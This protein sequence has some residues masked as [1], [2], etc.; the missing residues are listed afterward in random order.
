M[1]HNRFSIVSVDK[2]ARTVRVRGAAD[3][4]TD[5]SCGEA[6]IVTGEGPTHDLEQL[7]AGDIVTLEQKD[8]RAEQIRVVRR[9]WEEYSNP[10]W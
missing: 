1:A 8:G 7:F 2:A 10:G 9:V 4:C 3:V 6:M 5:L